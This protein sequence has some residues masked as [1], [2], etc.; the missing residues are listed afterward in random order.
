M[1]LL[2]VKPAAVHVSSEL[3]I[4]VTIVVKDGPI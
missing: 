3:G 4:E 2:T 1:A